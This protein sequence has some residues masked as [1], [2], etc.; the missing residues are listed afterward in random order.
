MSDKRR[1]EIENK[2]WYRSQR[3]IEHDGKWFFLTREGSTEGPFE[4]KQDAMEQLE[5]WVKVYQS[6]MLDETA[7]GLSLLPKD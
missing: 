3:F 2:A 5:K 4:S 1:N 7:D 6:G